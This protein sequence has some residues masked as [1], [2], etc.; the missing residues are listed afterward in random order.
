METVLTAGL[1]VD[2]VLVCGL[3]AH[4]CLLAFL[5]G[6]RR[7]R[8]DDVDALAALVRFLAGSSPFRR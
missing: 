3:L 6:Y 1:I 8:L 4:V 2:L 7:R 5:V